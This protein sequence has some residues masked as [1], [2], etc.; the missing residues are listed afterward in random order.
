MKNLIIITSLLLAAALLGSG[1][2]DQDPAQR[3]ELLTVNSLEEIEVMLQTRPV[4][5]E[6][7]AGWCPSCVEQKPIVE[8]LAAEYGDQVAFVY[9]DTDKQSQLAQHFNVYYI[10]DLSMI[11]SSKNGTFNYITRQGTLTGERQE[12]MMVGLTSKNVL[13]VIIQD[14]L[15][16]RSTN[17]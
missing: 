13:E 6:M 3:A 16:L 15:K 4:F 12:A 7:G 1:C 9:I 11:V 5:I 10:P 8:E 14:T 17:T 2:T